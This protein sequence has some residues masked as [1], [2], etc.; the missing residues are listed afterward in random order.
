MDKPRQAI[1][2]QEPC[3]QKYYAFRQQFASLVEGFNAIVGGNPRQLTFLYEKLK[4]R[5]GLDT[6]L[7]VLGGYGCP[8]CNYPSDEQILKDREALAWRLKLKN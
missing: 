1:E 7:Y 2:Q 4:E 3:C 5:L 6:L 8:V